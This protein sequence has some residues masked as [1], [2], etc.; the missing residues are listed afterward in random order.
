MDSDVQYMWK[1]STNCCDDFDVEDLKGGIWGGVDRTAAY[2]GERCRRDRPSGPVNTPSERVSPKI[3]V[4]QGGEC[5]PAAQKLAPPK[6]VPV[7]HP[8]TGNS[9]TAL[10]SIEYFY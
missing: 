6:S 2:P 7:A 3:I 4:E 5:G 8:T 9:S 10:L 1:M